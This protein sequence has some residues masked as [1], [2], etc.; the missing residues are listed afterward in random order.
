MSYDIEAVN[1]CR[2]TNHQSSIPSICLR[3]HKIPWA[4]VVVFIRRHCEVR[5][6]CLLT[7]GDGYAC[8]M[9]HMEIE[10]VDGEISF[11]NNVL[12]HKY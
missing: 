8:Q 2:N 1:G 10:Q 12:M 5:D 11:P 7:G 6:Y 4:S 3:T 9:V